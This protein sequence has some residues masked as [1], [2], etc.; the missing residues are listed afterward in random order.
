MSENTALGF[1]GGG[2]VTLDWKRRT[3]ISEHLL[4]LAERDTVRFWEE[5]ARE[6][7]IWFR[8]WE[9]ALEWNT[10]TTGTQPPWVRWFLG[11]KLNVCY[12]CVDRHVQTWRRN[13]AAIIWEGEPGDERV[14]TYDQ[15]LHQVQRCA[16]ML[17]LLGVQKGDRVTLYMPMIPELAIAM[18]ACARIGVVHSVVFGGFSA[19]ALRDR[20]NDSG[21]RVVI[22]ADGG[23]RRGKLY[24]SNKTQT[25]Q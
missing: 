17:R 22:T 19:Q 18:L 5:V 12:N 6:R 4:L 13:K 23:W 1:A 25:R 9:Q 20:I 7:L 3:P 2:T 21:S 16:S 14:L 10:P 15:L 11:G 24:H 8:T